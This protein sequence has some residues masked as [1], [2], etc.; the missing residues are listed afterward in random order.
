MAK[1]D[2]YV[3]IDEDMF[4]GMTTIGKIIRDAWVFGLL[5]ETET[6]KGWNN[7]GINDLLDKVNIEWDK[8]DCLVSHL[9]D[10]LRKRH[11]KIHDVALAKAREM[12]WSGEYETDGEGQSSLC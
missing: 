6:C 8:Y 12:G 11:Q 2:T 5:P 3:G 10:E 4:G 9:P 1:P 7:H